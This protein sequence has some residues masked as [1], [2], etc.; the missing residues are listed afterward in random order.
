MNHLLKYNFVKD[1]NDSDSSGLFYPGS[2]NLT[3][4]LCDKFAPN[5]KNG[6]ESENDDCSCELYTTAATDYKAIKESLHI[7]YDAL[8]KEAEEIQTIEK[9]KP[10]DCKLKSKMGTK[11]CKG[12]RKPELT[13]TE[14]SKNFTS[15]EVTVTIE[16]V[17]GCQTGC[18]AQQR[19]YA[20]K[21][22]VATRASG[23]LPKQKNVIGPIVVID[24]PERPA[25]TDGHISLSSDSETELNVSAFEEDENYEVSVKVWWKFERFDKFVI[26]RFQKI[27]S[28]FDHYSELEHVPQSQIWLTLSDVQVHPNDSPD[29]LKLTV[30]SVL[31]GGVVYGEVK[32]ASNQVKHTLNVDEM[33]LKVQR[34]GCKQPILIRINK[35][36]KMRVL[37]L[38]CAECLDVPAEK[39]KFSFDG[40][41]LNPNET[42]VDLDMEGGECIDVYI[43]EI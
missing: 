10:D 14:L 36:Q 16:Q 30:A 2:G 21:R 3:F 28:L 9:L 29:S 23:A 26:R 42:P 22:R 43:S 7:D 38:K 25:V 41:S 33:E 6:M 11:G 4:I 34:K 31:E 32:N 20:T 39:L 12:K 1:A 13:D 24:S 18:S 17:K 27:A 19:T 35:T 15:E 8:W 5:T 37:M 40:E